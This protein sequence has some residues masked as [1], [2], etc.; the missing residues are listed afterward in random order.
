M[1]SYTATSSEPRPNGAVAGWLLA[2]TSLLSLVFMLHHPSVSSTTTD[3]IVAEVS[4][5]ARLSMTV[6]GVLIALIFVQFYAL[7]VLSVRLG[8]RRGP[9]I[10][11]L[12]AQAT[13]VLAMLGAALIS[14]FLVPDLAEHL[15][16]ASPEALEMGRQQM[17]FAHHANQRLAEVGVVAMATAIAM[18]SAVLLATSGAN[19]LIGAAGLLLGSALATAM[20]AGRI[21]LHVHGMTL[22]LAILTLWYLAVG[23]QLIRRDI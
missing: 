10:A 21:T 3:Q 7:A 17:A 22:V 6:H 9:V 19:R 13:G 18:W 12:T 5:E 1:E 16:G 2:I 8:L 4:G 20:L 11:G 14:G 15:S 23:M